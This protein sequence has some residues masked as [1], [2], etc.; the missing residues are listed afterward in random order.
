MLQGRAR[1][2]LEAVNTIGQIKFD[3]VDLHTAAFA[4]SPRSGGSPS[5]ARAEIAAD[6]HF[7]L[8]R[9]A[10]LLGS[11]SR[12][13]PLGQVPGLM[14]TTEPTVS[15]LLR[16]GVSRAG[17]AQPATVPLQARIGADVTVMEA[18]L[19]RAAVDF[20]NRSDVAS[21]E[22]LIGSSATILILVLLF[23]EMYRRVWAARRTAERLSAENARL[24]ELSR[25]E[26]LTDPLTS[27]GNRRAFQQDVSALLEDVDADHELVAAIFDLN[28]FK[29][30]NDTFGHAA[31]DALLVRLA[32]ALKDSMDPEAG[33]YRL[34]G[35]EFCVVTSAGPDRGIGLIQAGADA[36]SDKGEGWE[37]SCAWGMAW[38]PSDAASPGEAL[39]LADARMYAQKAAR[40]TPA[41]QAAATLMQLL[42]ERDSELDAHTHNVARLAVA[43][44]TRLRVG[45]P[46]LANLRLAAQ[47]HD[48]GKMA[49]P[50]SILVKPGPLDE[51]EWAF[52][53]QHTIIGE[54]IMK[55]A[56]S[57]AEAAKLVRS[58][59]ERIDG[60]GYPD[61]LVGDAIPLG[62]RI[63][64]AC[65]AYDAMISDR[66]YHDAVDPDEAV[67]ELR[68]G[69]GTQFAPEV[70]EALCA[71]LRE[72]AVAW[73]RTPPP[74]PM[75]R[76][77][78]I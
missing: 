17:Y 54:R 64:A 33:V 26:A 66:C 27:L 49:I 47:L 31:G 65:D 50:E 73:D 9:T 61:G 20:G 44:A 36:L 55:A 28:G 57:L 2:S 14:R 37:I 40:S 42:A 30:Y 52:V 11:A 5:V 74:P 77:A 24:L 19:R 68:R 4:A 29:V 71:V 76:V 6:E 1:A 53:H 67:A 12:S 63:V 48:I 34:G 25:D 23:A 59:H 72:H 75:R 35:D 46:D 62:A 15:A 39:R 10:A 18:R 21:A 45:E 51:R 56:P 16:I 78:S 41:G 13:S 70:V 43:T 32:A 3:L 8:T 60:R 69:S 58:S 38:I 7:I 22:T